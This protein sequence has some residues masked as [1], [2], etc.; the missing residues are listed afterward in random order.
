MDN[1]RPAC[2]PCNS[3]KGSL[4]P[5]TDDLKNKIAA[6]VRALRASQST[7]CSVM[8]GEEVNDACQWEQ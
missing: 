8:D 5:F 6:E 3:R 7:A 2:S 4:W 1:L